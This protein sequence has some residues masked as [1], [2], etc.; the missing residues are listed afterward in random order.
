M[1]L[2]SPRH[3]HSAESIERDLSLSTRFDPAASLNNRSNPQN[4]Q[5]SATETIRNMK[6]QVDSMEEAMANLSTSMD[7]TTELRF[8]FV[9]ASESK[10]M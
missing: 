4:T 7:A 5:N 1:N 6:H 8:V 2:S 3:T 9:C 10:H